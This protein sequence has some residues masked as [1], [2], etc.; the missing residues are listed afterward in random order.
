MSFVPEPYEQFV[1]DLLTALT[2]GSVREEHQFTGSDGAYSLSTP[3]A[4][5]FTLK[6]T[7][8]RDDQYT[9][10]EQDTEF[11]YDQAAGIRWKPAA[12]L[13]DLSTYFY[14][15]YYRQDAPAR[16]TD[17]N[18]G[19]VT[20]T[21]AEAFARE[22]AVL[23]KQMDGIYRSAFIDLATGTSVDHIAA[24]L[25]ITRKDPRFASG[26]VLFKRGT[27]AP[28]DIL[29]PVGTV[30]STDQGQNFE[31]TDARTLRRGQLSIVVPIRAK[32]EG[33]PGKVDA[34]TI[35]NV[36][37]P[38][39]GID[40]VQNDSATFFASGRET[41]VELRNRVLG[42]LERAGK[43]TV[44]SIR[45]ALIE[46]IAEI[47]EENIQVSENAE[48]AG[49]VEVK[50]GIETSTPDLVTRVEESIFTARPAGVRV[51]HNLPTGTGSGSRQAADA[52]TR[53]QAVDDLKGQG[54]LRDL[55][56]VKAPVLA[57]MPDRVLVMR[58]EALL[59]LAG[60]NLSTAQKESIEDGVRT[61]IA[62]YI[63][64]LPMGAALWFNKLLG[65]VVQPDQI[66]DASLLVGA[67][68][69][70][71]FDGVAANLSTENRKA[72]IDPQ[73]IFVGLMDEVV[74]V[75]VVVQLELKP[76]VPPDPKP[77]VQVEPKPTVKTTG[78]VPDSKTLTPP[79]S[80]AVNRLLA[81]GTRNIQRQD[82][83]S[84]IRSAVNAAAPQ[85][86]LVADNPV[87]LNATFVESG[88]LLNNADAVALA[89]NEAPRLGVLTVN[90]KGALDG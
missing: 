1:D 6:V 35:K 51:T 89:E 71:A 9:V 45:Y 41:D 66:I 11:T 52:I 55:L 25:A 36:N 61:T 57:A 14:V 67:E 73:R 15:S 28:G 37:R 40:A 39:F 26:E 64:G 8:T 19:S 54:E 20:T 18:P 5:P 50:L 84:A 62:N 75:D 7:G 56:H 13:P 72:K 34:G 76:P 33:T 16:L 90:V 86:Q 27:P 2:G 43:A 46:D 59:R 47:S 24:L 69:G 88:R 58:A 65:L 4:I 48:I 22:F 42:A 83:V 31:T 81:S 21:L 10:F 85:L 12:K 38:I 30:V 29:I 87:V 80:D 79:L 74:T 82:L 3:G 68:S 63:N 77:G 60:Q 49:L 32:V 23:H 53:A 44:E 78:P 17:R 70:G